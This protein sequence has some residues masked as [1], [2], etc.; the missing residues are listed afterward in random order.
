MQR[1][2][3]VQRMQ[4]MDRL[5][6]DLGLSS[7]CLME[8][9]G[10]GCAR[11]LLKRL[12]D[13]GEIRLAILCG[14]GNNG[15]DGFVIARHL[16]QAGLDPQVFAIGVAAKASPDA[17]ANRAILSNLGLPIHEIL[18]E[19]DLPDLRSF[20][21]LVDCLLGTG[22][23]GAARGL[24][25]RMI[26]LAGDSGVPLVAVDIPSGAEGDSGRLPG[27]FTQA[28]MTLTM[29]APKRGL[30]LQPAAAICGELRAV[31]IGYDPEWFSKPED[32]TLPALEDL[33]VALPARHPGIHKNR[34]GR[35]L[36]IAGSTGMTGAAMLACKTAL[37]SGSGMVKLACPASLNAVFEIALPEVLT[38]ALPDEG[39]GFLGSQHAERLA[40]ELKWA[41]AVLL[42]PGLGRDEQSL[43]LC[44]SLAAACDTKLVIDADAL[45]A[46]AGMA[47]DLA[48]LECEIVLTPHA[49]ELAVLTG[50][51]AAD[52]AETLEQAIDLADASDTTILMKGAP[53]AV[54]GYAGGVTINGSGN[55]GLATAG[56]GDVLAGLIAG[57]CA[58][59]VAAEDAARL[60]C[61]LHG[62]AADRVRDRLG[63][64][65]LIAGDL[66]EELPAALQEAA[67]AT[68]E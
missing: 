66:L 61:W 49:G 32:W 16:L 37:R 26:Q 46:F 63:E 20:D 17:A 36:V 5:A 58:Q 40:E 21:L 19:E 59:G 53:S 64:R 11:Q 45:H 38:L 43:S 9:A 30:L 50:R 25:L 33:A 65:S 4:A 35:V 1:V 41:D 55:P 23:K 22:L 31:S 57:L 27:C 29:A 3:S 62:R 18:G 24:P 10:A 8:N 54:I 60:G 51:E 39:A 7:L 67:K 47:E 13:S 68:G 28:E 52:H 56:S 2:L 42:G 34:A 14:S 48:E 12:Q 15:G 44:R 6:V